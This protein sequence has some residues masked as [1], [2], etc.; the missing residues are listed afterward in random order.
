MTAGNSKFHLA[1][2]AS[3]AVLALASSDAAASDEARSLLEQVASAAQAMRSAA[4]DATLDTTAGT[5]TRKVS[6]HVKV[7]RLDVA[8]DPIGA[9]ISVEGESA[10]NNV[11]T[12]TFH[13]VYD[14]E[15][16]RKLLPAQKLMLEG[17]PRHG[18][19]AVLRGPHDKL[20]LTELL[21][22]APLA[23]ELAAPEIS[24]EGDADVA[25]TSCRIIGVKYA[26]EGSSARIFV[27]PTDSLPRRIERKFLA[28]N[29][30]PVQ[31]TMTISNLQTNVG[32]DDSAFTLAAPEGFRVEK[33]SMKP[34]P[35]ILP[36]SVAPEFELKDELGKTYKLSD[37]KGKVVVLDFWSTTCPHCANAAPAVQ[38]LYDKYKG[39]GVE[40]FGIHCRDNPGADVA[41]YHRSRG[42]TYPILVD[43]NTAA[44]HYTLKSIPGF[45]IIDGKG[46]V[47]DRLSG[48]P[49]HQE[50][51]I[52]QAIQKALAQTSR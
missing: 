35:E 4:Y 49:G 36:G 39:R 46:I 20:I 31:T 30:N 7:A 22:R 17:D 12:E 45:Y 19:G 23:N 41:G 21:G 34:R 18:G 32:L 5:S 6:G 38:R 50:A 43:G 14:G 16:I 27:N 13:V 25:G 37:M 24:L 11:A 8:D 3:A 10:G 40:V 44:I 42:L 52:D 9:M 48:F 47:V 28:A 29:G 1:L 15:M 51:S 33:F 26:A 2:C